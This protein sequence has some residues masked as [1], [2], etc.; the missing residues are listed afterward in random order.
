V[1]FVW[2]ND[3]KRRLGVD[4]PFEYTSDNLMDEA[5]KTRIKHVFGDFQVLDLV[6]VFGL[7]A[8]LI[9]ITQECAHQALTQGSRYVRGS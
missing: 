4:V 8:D 3:A 2:K 9:W 6:E 5:R 7:R 1:H